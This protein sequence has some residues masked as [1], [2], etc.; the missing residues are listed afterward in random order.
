MASHDESIPA[1][2]AGTGQHQDRSAA[3]GNQVARQ[4]GCC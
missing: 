3:V 2:V 4:L 1:I